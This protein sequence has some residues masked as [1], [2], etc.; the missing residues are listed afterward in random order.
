MRVTEITTNFMQTS[1]KPV[2]S[3]DEIQIVLSTIALK[4]PKKL[5]FSWFTGVCFQFIPIDLIEKN[6][7]METLIL[8]KMLL[9]VPSINIEEKKF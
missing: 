6:P 9:T 1:S 8:K 2:T 3:T 4:T 5:I 7:I